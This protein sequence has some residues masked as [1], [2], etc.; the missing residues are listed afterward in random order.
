[1]ICVCCNL[2]LEF[3][4]YFVFQHYI[5]WFSIITV[6][7]VWVCAYNYQY[8]RPFWGLASYFI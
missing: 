6:R 8:T 3:I 2:F 4:I 7:C 1:M 5:P